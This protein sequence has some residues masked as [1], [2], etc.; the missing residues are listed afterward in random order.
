MINKNKKPKLTFAF[1]FPMGIE[2]VFCPGLAAQTSGHCWQDFGIP[3]HCPP[4]NGGKQLPLIEPLSGIWVTI[5]N[6]FFFLAFYQFTEKY[7]LH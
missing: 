1:P 4:N 6:I 2:M 7:Q 5:Y 3:E